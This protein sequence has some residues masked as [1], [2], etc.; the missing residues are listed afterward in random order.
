MQ[1]YSNPKAGRMPSANGINSKVSTPAGA[2][3]K[4]LGNTS[5]SPLA[6]GSPKGSVKGF[7]GGIINPKIGR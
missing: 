7:S 6:G 3:G 4:S 5:E 1:N 2:M